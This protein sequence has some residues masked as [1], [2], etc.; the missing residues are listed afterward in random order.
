MQ[1]L[2]KDNEAVTQMQLIKKNG[3]V[4]QMLQEDMF[5]NIYPTE[6]FRPWEVSYMDIA[7]I[8]STMISGL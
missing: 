8:I 1:L 5:D 4:T 7:H 3:A 6:G 2:I